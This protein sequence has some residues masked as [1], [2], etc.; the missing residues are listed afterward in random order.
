MAERVVLVVDD[1]AA[2]RTVLA[3]FLR[4][5]GYEVVSAAGVDEAVQ[6]ASNRTIDLVLTD[7]NMRKT[8][9]SSS[10]ACALNPELPVI[11]MT[12]CDTVAAPC[13]R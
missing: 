5:R 11:V 12:A 2:Q 9:W 13:P 10:T 1:E 8:A 6:Q 3:G 7:L 4:K